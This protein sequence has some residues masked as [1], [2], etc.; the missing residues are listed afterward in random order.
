[1]GE[2]H[3]YRQ[4]SQITTQN[5][6]ISSVYL[7]LAK[8]SSQYNIYGRDASICTIKTICTQSA[9]QNTIQHKHLSNIT[10]IYIYI[11]RLICTMY[12]VYITRG[13]INC[14]FNIIVYIYIYMALDMYNVHCIYYG[15]IYTMYIVYII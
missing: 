5:W 1:L 9:L 6:L 3:K 2:K 14:Q 15:R 8:Y 7:K 11:W 4:Q 13:F 10:F 12:I